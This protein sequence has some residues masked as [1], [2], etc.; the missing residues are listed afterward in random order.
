[1]GCSAHILALV[2]AFLDFPFKSTMEHA[3]EAAYIDPPSPYLAFL[4]SFLLGLGDAF[5][6]TQIMSILGSI[7]EKKSAA[8][9]AIFKLAQ[10]S[11]AGVALC[12][13]AA[14]VLPFQLLILAVL[15][16]LGTNVFCIVEWKT[17]NNQ[18]RLP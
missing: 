9:F 7:F 2:V 15:C 3:N 16:I 10:S 8:A 1:M 18:H 17:R 11:M 14:I 6:N 13:S 4:G 5:F 12:Y